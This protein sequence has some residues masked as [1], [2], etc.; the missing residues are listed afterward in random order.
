MGLR[1]QHVRV[2][3]VQLLDTR[4]DVLPERWP[5][6]HVVILTSGRRLTP[7]GNKAGLRRPTHRRGTADLKE[8]LHVHR[9]RLPHVPRVRFI[10]VQPLQTI[11][12]LPAQQGV[13][14]RRLLGIEKTILCV[15]DFSSTFIHVYTF[16]LF[17]IK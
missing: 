4:R 14:V 5:E 9:R 7:G 10:L 8:V 13:Q 17:D 3:G 12:I 11:E 2:F 15:Y 16:Y 1:T 6:E